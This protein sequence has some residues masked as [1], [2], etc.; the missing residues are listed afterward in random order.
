MEYPAIIQQSTRRE[1]LGAA[2]LGA[3]LSGGAA[4]RGAG[5]LRRGRG[6]PAETGLV[7]EPPPAVAKHWCQHEVGGRVSLLR[8][9][10]VTVCQLARR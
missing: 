4:V 10:G 7:L 1:R 5:E 8:R 2:R 3:G 6:R 9:R